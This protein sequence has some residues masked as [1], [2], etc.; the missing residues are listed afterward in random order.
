MLKFIPLGKNVLDIKEYVPKSKIS[1]CDISL[2]VKYMWRDDFKIEYAIYNDTLI[3]KESCRDYQNAF[4]YPIGSDVDGALKQIEDYC[5]QKGKSLKFCCIDNETAVQLSSRY[6]RVKITNDRDWSDYIY[7]AEKFRTYSGKKL[8]GQRNHVNKFKKL[9]PNYTFCEY[10]VDK[11]PAVKQ[12]LSDFER[13]AD[14]SAWG[15]QEEFNKITDYIEN[16]QNINQVGGLLMV[17]GKVIG[18]SFGEILGDTLIVHVEKALYSY[19]GAYP[20]LAQEFTK[21][22]A[23]KKVKYINREEDCGDMGLRISKLQYKPIEIKQ[24]NL[25]DVFTTA[26]KITLPIGFETER[27]TVADTKDKDNADY[28]RLA[29]DDELNKLWGYDYRED[30]NGSQPTEQYFA[31]FRKGLADKGE[32][33]SLMVKEKATGKNVGE[34]VIWNFGYHNDAEIGFRFFKEE[35]GKGYAYESASALIKYLSEVVGV[36][37]IKDRAFKQNAP[38][39]KLIKKLG[40]TLTCED[41]EKILLPNESLRK[42]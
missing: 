4:Y 28:F 31:T 3:M 29:F 32:E 8:S 38:S 5:L 30:L 42:K 14:F 40:F 26:Q 35:Q 41:E 18:L 21:A 12:F 33:F 23:D 34:L 17:D 24:K 2:G 16:A 10:S 27:L 15:A 19:E 6:E 22:F 7:D 25:V 11:L 20:T 36:T 13:G 39:N 37:L 9:Y 1:F